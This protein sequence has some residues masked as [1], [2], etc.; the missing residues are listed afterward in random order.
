MK[1]STLTLLL[2]AAAFS[3]GADTLKAQDFDGDPLVNINNKNEDL[4]FSVGARL[5]A[6][7]AYYGTEYTEMKSG[8][9]IT[10]ARIRTSLTYK[11][12]YFYADFDF[13]GGKFTQKN[14]FMQ[15]TL[16]NDKGGNHV[17]KAGYYN[18]PASMA[19]NT[20]L[21][22][23]HFI[24]RPAPAMALSPGRE[25]GVSYK[26]YNKN[27]LFNQ[28]VFVENMYN[29]QSAG[30]QGLTVGGRWLYRPLNDEN[31]ALHIGASARYGHISTGTEY[32]DGLGIIKTQL[33]LGTPMETYVD[34]TEFVQ[35]SL[36]W[37]SDQLNVGAEVSYNNDKFF[38]RGEYMYK[39]VWKERD[40]YKIFVDD[41]GTNPL[42]NWGTYEAWSGAYP[43]RTNNFHGGY[44]EA[45]YQIFGK[46]YKYNSA[47]GVLGGLNGKS[48]EV[49]ARYSYTGLNDIVEGELYV[50]G[51]DQ[52]YPS[53]QIADYPTE[54]TSVGGG[55][56]H[57]VTVGVNYS[58]NKFAQVMLDYTYTSLDKDFYVY[59]KN[60]HTVQA[61]LL[62]SF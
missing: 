23:Y 4:R 5:M 18:D 19:R 15:Y 40:S 51:R 54:S 46:G 11:D 32:R 1:K 24:S 42:F 50:P 20:S 7:A 16:S 21:G 35:T 43:L 62:F 34:Q 31:G 53:G 13:S 22:S 38:A 10:D 61:R 33:D 6:D 17:I 47:E 57:A 28:G 58:F 30:S 56:M 27:M 36:P 2:A 60:F 29:N 41:L 9:A 12:W 8:A 39:R 52:Y 14:I 59:D 49:V 3:F 55:N 45:G 26:F 25:L 44:V 37:A 48:L